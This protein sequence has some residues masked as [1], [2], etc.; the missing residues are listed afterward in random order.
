M[1]FSPSS[2][3]PSTYQAQLATLVKSAPDGDGWLHEIKYDG[4][5]IGAVI[6]GKSV[7]LISRRGNDWTANFK[8]IAG[9]LRKLK[10]D[11]AMLD[12]EAAIVLPDGRT[13]PSSGAGPEL[14]SNPAT[15]RTRLS[16][17][18]VLRPVE[19]ENPPRVRRAGGDG[20]PDVLDEVLFVAG[21]PDRRRDHR[22]CCDVKARDQA[23]RSVTDVLV[24][25]PLHQTGLHRQCRRRPLQRLD[26]GLLVRRSDREAPHGLIRTP[27]KCRSWI[28]AARRRWRLREVRQ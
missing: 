25:P 14:S 11:S 28:S 12:G 17:K 22:T 27:H 23:L 10:V 3:D 5:R 6:D 7:S 26:S 20:L 18:W 19:D 2:R 4:Y 8:E 1:R 21:G 9:A 13:T 16:E 24:L 15:R